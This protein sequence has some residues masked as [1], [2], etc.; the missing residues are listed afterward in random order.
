MKSI[1]SNEKVCL[2]CKTPYD[3][4]KHHIYYGTGNRKI[5]EREGCW[6]YLCGAHHNL[7]KWGVHF[8]KDLDLRIKQECQERWERKNGTR[9][10]FIQTFGKSYL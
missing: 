3:L 1:M 9:E 5:S 10:Q 7:S 4:H 8:N 2:V 6:C